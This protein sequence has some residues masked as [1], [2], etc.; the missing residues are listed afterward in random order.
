MAK[1]KKRPRQTQSTIFKLQMD[2]KSQWECASISAKIKTLR[3]ATNDQAQLLTIL[4]SLNIV[5]GNKTEIRHDQ[6]EEIISTLRT[7]RNK[8]PSST[9]ATKKKPR[10]HPLLPDIGNKRKPS[11]G[12][13]KQII[14][15]KTKQLEA[16]ARNTTKHWVVDE[17]E[18]YL[19]PQDDTQ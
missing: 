14:A 4:K 5:E 3:A 7:T 15:N 18:D 1:L 10:K 12:L 11:I 16:K 19:V 17:D 2:H 13:R 9:R 8:P 6:L